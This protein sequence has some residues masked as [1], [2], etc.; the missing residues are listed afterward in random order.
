MLR[1]RSHFWALVEGVEPETV[2]ARFSGRRRD[3]YL[4]APEPFEVRVDPDLVELGRRTFAVS[5]EGFGQAAGID[6]RAVE[7]D[8]ARVDL[9]RA[10]PDT[11][12]GEARGRGAR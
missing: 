3:L 9:R 12:G 10:G 6:V 5:H 2:R 4:L 8:T 1:A 7:P 11:E